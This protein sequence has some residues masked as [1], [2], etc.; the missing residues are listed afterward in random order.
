[1]PHIEML[2]SG[3]RG[4]AAVASFGWSGCYLVTS[5]SGRLLLFDTAGYNERAT[6]INSL[7][8]L[9]VAPEDAD[10]APLSHPHFDHAANWGL[11]ANAEF[12][13]H[14]REIAYADSRGADGAVLGITAGVAGAWPLALDFCRD[15]SEDGSQV[16]HVPGHTPGCIALSN[17]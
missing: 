14:A 17:W 5:A 4:R 3:F 6:V 9:S 1:M 11:F 15:W 12:I 2:L 16:I 13:V 7:A 8:K 10:F